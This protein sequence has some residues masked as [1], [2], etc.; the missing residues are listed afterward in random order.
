MTAA[1]TEISGAIDL[2][3]TSARYM[4]PPP[5]NQVS[6]EPQSSSPA[7]ARCFF[8]ILVPLVVVNS[9][10]FSNLVRRT[11]NF[12]VAFGAA[13][14]SPRPVD[15]ASSP[16]RRY[17]LSPESNPSSS[18][19]HV[20]ASIRR[21][22]GVLFPDRPRASIHLQY[23]LWVEDWHK[24][25]RFAWGTSVLS[26]MYREMGRSVLQMTQSSS[27]GGDLGGWSALLQ[28]G[29]WEQF[30]Y[31]APLHTETGAQIT[32]DAFPHGV[33]WLSAQTRQHG[34]QFY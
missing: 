17:N 8:L 11:T 26:Y 28:L 22:R 18:S 25:G 23:L 10:A 7:T 30:S 13:T 3:I 21:C 4:L 5:S 20:S 29:A 16:D 32:E 27:T 2:P 24:A 14:I 15:I 6:V 12:L 1:K 19:L 9:A 34:N 31:T 33:R